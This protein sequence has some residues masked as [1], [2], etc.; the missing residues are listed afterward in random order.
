MKGAPKR[1]ESLSETF[2]KLLN[3][4][5]EQAAAYFGKNTSIG[6]QLRQLAPDVPLKDIVGI[7]ALITLANDTDPRL[8]RE[9]GDRTEG[10]VEQRVDVTTAGQPLTW[11]EFIK[12]ATGNDK[13]DPGDN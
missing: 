5:K 9:L 3:M 1:G 4:D 8:L 13:P 7:R 12:N 6:R 11:G 2:K 10:K